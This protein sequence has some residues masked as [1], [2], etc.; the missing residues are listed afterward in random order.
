MSAFVADGSFPNGSGTGAEDTAY[1]S[2]RHR[3]FVTNTFTNTVDVLNVHDPLNP[4]QDPLVK[5]STAVPDG[6]DITFVAYSHGI[7]AVA[8][9]NA[10][11]VDQPGVVQ[12]YRTLADGDLEL[13]NTLTVGFDP[14]EVHFSR[15][16]SKL[17][18][19]NSGSPNFD[20][21]ANPIDPS[22]SIT[23]DR[24]L[25]WTDTRACGLSIDFAQFDSMVDDLRS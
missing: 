8:A 7:L 10:Q 16:G 23:R 12:L 11:A 24:S 22:G 4:I 6:T 21:L 15:D 1:D 3:L 17:A 18:V 2:A 13:A 19:A 9:S 25:A 14:D 20:D 5:T